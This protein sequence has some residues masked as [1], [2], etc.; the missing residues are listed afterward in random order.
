MYMYKYMYIYIYMRMSVQYIYMHIYMLYCAYIICHHNMNMMH[1]S[2]IILQLPVS[3]YT[4]VTK[5]L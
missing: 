5:F 1:L 3:T 4:R 2:L